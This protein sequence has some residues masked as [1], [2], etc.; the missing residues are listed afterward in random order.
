MDKPTECN[1]GTVKATFVDNAQLSALVGKDSASSTNNS[2]SSAS[3]SKTT[4]SSTSTPT[5]AAASLQNWAYT[6]VGWGTVMT[7]LC[8]VTL[9]GA[10]AI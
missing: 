9:G 5:G 1:N 2:P 8:M 6:G 4:S 7:A 10:L 3:G